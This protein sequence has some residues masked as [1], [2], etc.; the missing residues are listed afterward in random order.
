MLKLY[1]EC[2]DPLARKPDGTLKYGKVKSFVKLESY[3]EYKHARAI[4]SRHDIFKCLIGPALHAIDLVVYE[5]KYFIKKIP[6]DQRASYIASQFSKSSSGFVVTD[7][8]Q[9]EAAFTADVMEDSEFKLIDYMLQKH[10]ARELVMKLMHEVL[11]GDNECHF[12]LLTML[13]KA[14][15]MSGEMSTSLGNGFT[16]LMSFL[17]ECEEQGCTEVPGVVEGDDGLFCPVGGVPTAAGLALNGFTVKLQ[18]VDDFNEASFCGFIFEMEDQI[19]IKTPIELLINF[20]WLPSRYSNCGINKRLGLYKSK[21]LSYA[22][23]FPGCPIIAA[24]S[25]YVLRRTQH[26]KYGKT[27]FDG[28]WYANLFR[29]HLKTYQANGCKIPDVKTPYTTRLLFEK[30]TGISPPQQIT[31]EKYFDNFNGDHFSH[32]IL[33]T[34]APAINMEHFVNYTSSLETDDCPI[35]PSR[36]MVNRNPRSLMPMKGGKTRPHLYSRPVGLDGSSL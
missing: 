27:P 33:D 20:G 2:I 32:P 21:A 9:Y 3:P 14:T 34:F 10:P 6:V 5:N 15:R 26:V 23:Q 31:V 17:F 35:L 29:E 36:E 25:R 22:H 13:I 16:N 19:N 30:I 1:H 4:N 7:H 28:I 8:S 24:F 12:E 18:V 11:A